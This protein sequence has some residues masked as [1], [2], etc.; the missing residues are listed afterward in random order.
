VFEKTCLQKGL[1]YAGGITT[2]GEFPKEAYAAEKEVGGLR[3][4]DRQILIHI[5]IYTHYNIGFTDN[6]FTTA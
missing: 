6:C 3:R 4:L 2:S 1:S 5:A